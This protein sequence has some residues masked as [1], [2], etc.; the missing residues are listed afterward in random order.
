M[1]AEG[2][3][4][5]VSSLF[6]PNGKKRSKYIQNVYVCIA[7]KK[8][9][10][11]YSECVCLYCKTFCCNS[12][13]IQANVC[14]TASSVTSVYTKSVWPLT[15]CVI[16][17]KKAFTRRCKSDLHD[18]LLWVT[19]FHLKF[20]KV[21]EVQPSFGRAV[22]GDEVDS[23]IGNHGLHNRQER[24]FF[25]QHAVRCLIVA[26]EYQSVLSN[27]VHNFQDHEIFLAFSF[28]SYKANH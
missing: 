27:A 25:H 3:S 17:V 11:I 4:P 7:K 6:S 13:T 14:V 15:T 12:V 21:V 10:K 1:T 20:S 5:A 16:T 26:R 9:I 28:R 23:P 24:A 18:L 19:W 2:A 22:Q 8:K